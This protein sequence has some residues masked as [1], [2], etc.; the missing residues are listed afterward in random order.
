MFKHMTSCT[1]NENREEKDR[2]MLE[3]T[4]AIDEL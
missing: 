3:K 4:D 2:E 1:K